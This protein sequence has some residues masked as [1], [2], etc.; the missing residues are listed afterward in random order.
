MWSL[1]KQID[2]ARRWQGRLLDVAGL[3]PQEAPHRVVHSESGFHLKAYADHQAEGPVLLMVPAPIKRA[4]IWDLAP[5]AS[6]VRHCLS[7]GIRVYLIEWERPVPKQQDTGLAEYA[8]RFILAALEAVAA[9]TGQQRLFV[10]GHSLGG[11]FGAIFAA[12][13]PERVQGLILLEAPVHFAQHAGAFAPLVALAPRAQFLTNAL[14]NIS[15]TF[16]NQMSYLASPMAF[17]GARWVDWFLS[18]PDAEAVQIHLRVERWTLDE[19]PLPRQLFEEVVEELYRE[20]RFMGGTLI[21]NGR[22][23]VAEGIGA[24]LLSVVDPRSRVVPPESVLPF[25]EAAHSPDRQV[26]WYEGDKG[27]ALQHVGVLVGKNA[28]QHLWPEILEWIFDHSSPACRPQIPD[29]A[30]PRARAGSD[31]RGKSPS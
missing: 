3:G 28:H 20:D 17:G 11:T 29:R 6:A 14:G 1:Y 5:G 9:E 31:H 23:A 25:H 4:Y 19:M 10:A 30:P 2:Q 22:A 13:Y 8:D 16:L 26:L 24:P 7:N 21:V 27:V 12:L 15:G 18:L